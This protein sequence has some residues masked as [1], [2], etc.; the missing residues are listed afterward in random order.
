MHI[1]GYWAGGDE[2]Y[3]IIKEDNV[4]YLENKDGREIFLKSDF[5]WAIT[6]PWDKMNYV[7]YKNED[8]KYEAIYSSIVYDFIEY[9]ITGIGDT[10]NEAILNMIKNIV[11]LFC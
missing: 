9:M 5:K 7:L 2:S 1:G 6:N 3:E 11:N 10:E 4:Y 8:G